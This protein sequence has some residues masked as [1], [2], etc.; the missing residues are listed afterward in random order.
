LIN[1]TIGDLRIEGSIEAVTLFGSTVTGKA[2]LADNR[3]PRPMQIVGNTFRA[4]VACS[5]N[6]APPDDGGTANTFEGGATGQC[7]K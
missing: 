5:G 3:T 4:A 2:A 6:S 1:S 7:G